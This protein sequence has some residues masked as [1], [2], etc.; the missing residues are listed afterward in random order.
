MEKI[1]F[2]IPCY[3]SENTI[4]NVVDEIVALIKPSNYNYEIILINDCSPDNVSSVLSSLSK[5]DNITYIE[6]TKN[7]GQASAIMAGLSLSTGDYTFIL[8]DD[9][10]SPIEATFLLLEKLKAD[11]ADA[12]FGVCNNTKFN[13][14]RKFGS[15]INELMSN[16]MIGIPKGQHIISFYVLTAQLIKEIC[17]YDQP[18]T[19]I[20]GLVFRSTSKVSFLDVSHRSRTSGKSGYSFS[21]LVSVWLNGFT[22][23]SIKPLHFVSILGFFTAGIG[24]LCCILVI[25]YRLCVPNVNIGWASI[26]SIILFIGGVNFIILGLIGEYIG[27]IYMCINKTPQYIIKSINKK[28]DAINN[29]EESDCVN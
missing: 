29:N 12:V 16:A 8:D 11:K 14:F 9:G 13:L 28:D 1:S 22:A 4:T 2:V 23:F 10:Q 7:F 3:R 27:R 6:L 15:K 17:K 20:S 21:R 24:F 18:Y 19:Y 25:I 26:M 5:Q